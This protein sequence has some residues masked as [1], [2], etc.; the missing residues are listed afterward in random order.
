MT[1]LLT[2]LEPNTTY[3]VRVAA[4]NGKGQGEF[5]HTETFQTL[6]IRKHGFP[7]LPPSPSLTSA[8]TLFHEMKPFVFCLPSPL[9][10]PRPPP[11]PTR[12]PSPPASQGQRGAGRVYRLGPVQRDHG[13]MPL[14]GSISSYNSVRRPG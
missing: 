11:P 4:V 12:D 14:G 8:C 5:S 6:P 3:E 1:V 9:S 7:P 2:S 13:G 10:P